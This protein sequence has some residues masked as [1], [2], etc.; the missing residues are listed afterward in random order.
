MTSS[1]GLRCSCRKTSNAQP[2]PVQTAM[3]VATCAFRSSLSA[4]QSS[5]LAMIQCRQDRRTKAVVDEAMAP[6][7][8]RGFSRRTWDF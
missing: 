7:V 3:D 5:T 4:R 2:T 6:F 1:F 8:A